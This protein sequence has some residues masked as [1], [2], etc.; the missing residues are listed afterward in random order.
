MSIQLLDIAKPYTIISNI[1][2]GVRKTI[3]GER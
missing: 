3:N 1:P 2:S